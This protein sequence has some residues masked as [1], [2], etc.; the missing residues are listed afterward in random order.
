MEWT[1]AAIDAG[2]HV[3]CEKPMALTP[4]D[5]DRVA[6]AAAAFGVVVEEGLMY[7]HEPL[8]ARVMS[9]V[10]DGAIGAVRAIVAGFTYAQS[11]AGDVRLD[12]AL[13][14]GAFWDVGCYPVT[15]ACLRR[16]ATIPRWSSGRRSGGRPAWTRSSRACCD[17]PAAS[18]PTSTR[19]SARPTAP[20]SR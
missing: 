4:H 10:S 19:G 8:T 6:A 9:L 13:G 16:R 20:G 5:V 14:G 15:Y 2:K 18:R 12:P 3:L 7:R 1:L 11:R 17:F